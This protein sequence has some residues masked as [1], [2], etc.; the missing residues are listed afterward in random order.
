MFRLAHVT[1]PHF[2]G[3]HG[4]RI[5]TL[6]NKRAIG[7][8]NLALN[9]RRKHKGEL[10]EALVGDLRA[11]AVDHLAV[12]GDLSNVSLEGEWREALRWLES[13][14]APPDAVTVIP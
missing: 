3:F 12:T 7:L 2:R 1:D 4:T 13:Y 14:G 5:A 10:L 11:Q 8:M 6:A 9:R